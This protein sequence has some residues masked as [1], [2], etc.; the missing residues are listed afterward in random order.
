MGA[1]LDV[2]LVYVLLNLPW[3]TRRPPPLAIPYKSLDSCQTFLR[4]LSLYDKK[5]NTFMH[6]SRTYWFKEALELPCAIC[7]RLWAV[8]NR[9]YGRD[10]RFFHLGSVTDAT[11]EHMFDKTAQLGSTIYERPEIRRR[12]LQ[13]KARTVVFKCGLH[14]AELLFESWNGKSQNM[15][16]DW[17]PINRTK[18][19]TLIR[20]QNFDRIILVA[21]KR[22]I[23]SNRST[24]NTAS[25]T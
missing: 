17:L 23:S 4:G 7:V 2:N 18:H 3:H 5:K 24:E 15:L 8:F 13:T 11:P 9:R 25:L 21:T 12:D 16:P 14:H 1:A 6:Q 22:L 10:S 19:K 20:V